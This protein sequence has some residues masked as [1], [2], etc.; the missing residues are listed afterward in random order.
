MALTS[1]KQVQDFI[2]KV[3]T[4]NGQIGD[5]ASAPHQAFWNT[6]YNNFVH[7]NVPHVND[8]NTG[9]PLPILVIGNSDGSTIIH[10][11]RGTDLF[12]PNTGVF[13]RMPSSGPPFFTDAQIK[14][15][16]DW[17]DAGCPE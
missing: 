8:P 11:L 17:I 3:L 6:S 1:F 9:N 2:T 7:G 12:D 14:E 4:D 10:A 5:V 16:A 13:S 15:I